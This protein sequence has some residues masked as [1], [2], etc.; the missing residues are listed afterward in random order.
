MKLRRTIFLVHLMAG[1]VVGAVVLFLAATGFLLAWQKAVL[2]WQERSYHSTPLPSHPSALPLDAL[3]AI[4]GASSGRKPESITL[5]SDREAPAEIDFGRTRRLFLDRYSGAVLGAGATR[6]RAFFDTVTGL[7]R[8]FGMST[9]HHA[10]AKLV[11]GA[12]SLALLLMIFTG[13]FLW[14]PRSWSRQRL[15]VAAFPRWGLRGRAR[16][17]NVHNVVGLWAGI[18]LAVIALTGAILAYGWM[19]SLLYFATGSRPAQLAP[20]QRS[21]A[22]TISS[23]HHAVSVTMQQVFDE[24]QREANGWRSIRIVLPEAGDHKIEAI[25]DFSD[26]GRPDQQAAMEFD[27]ASGNL[28]RFTT[29]S[30]FSLGKQLR[31]FVKYVHTGEAGGWAGETLAGLTSLACCVLVW[32]GLAM[33]LRRRRTKR[34]PLLPIKAESTKGAHAPHP[35]RNTILRINGTGRRNA[36]R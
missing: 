26:G 15:S 14:L 35:I 28:V 12:F 25:V 20:A 4:A 5:R 11:K 21:E 33:A 30:S 17:W 32:T 8:W 27:R 13:A 29:F 1:C 16:D 7:H 34:S 2:A 18:P 3:A 36:S 9:E 23:V 22:R 10:S 31:S 24:I 6:A 19:T